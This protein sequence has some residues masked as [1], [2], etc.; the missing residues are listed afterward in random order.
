MVESLSLWMR[1]RRKM[2]SQKCLLK[3]KWGKKTAFRRKK[4][5]EK[6]GYQKSL[7]ESTIFTGIAA[8]NDFGG[9]VMKSN[10]WRSFS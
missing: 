10:R 8:Q 2:G 1:L 4:L 5:G 9:V 3:K 6:K 7:S